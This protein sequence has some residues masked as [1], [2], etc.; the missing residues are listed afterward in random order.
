VLLND[1]RDADIGHPK[2]VSAILILEHKCSI[3]YKKYGGS[4]EQK[5][6]LAPYTKWFKTSSHSALIYDY[7]SI[8]L[9]PS[10]LTAGICGRDCCKKDLDLLQ[11]EISDNT[12][13]LGL[14]LD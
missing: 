13:D 12:L 6:R 3:L 7:V 2:I 1:G 9:F 10:H 5:V 4:G 8:S 11:P 14:D